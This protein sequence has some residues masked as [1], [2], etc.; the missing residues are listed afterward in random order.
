MR[1][2]IAAILGCDLEQVSVKATTTEKLGFVGK[3]EGISAHAVVLL[4]KKLSGFLY[5]PSTS[6]ILRLDEATISPFDIF[7]TYSVAKT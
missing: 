6:D 5:Y 7:K 1:E 4:K 3:G 2:T